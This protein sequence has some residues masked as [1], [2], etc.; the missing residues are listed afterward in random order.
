V[1]VSIGGLVLT[2]VGSAVGQIVGLDDATATL[3]TAAFV[4]L[5]ALIG[6]GIMLAS[7][8][9]LSDYG[10]RR[11]THLPATWWAAPL[12]VAPVAVIAISGFE[13]KPGLLVPYLALTLAVG[14]NEEI[15]FRGLALAAVRRK[16]VKP[17]IAAASLLF[18]VL[19]LANALAGKPGLYLILQLGFATLVGLVLAELVAITGSLWIPIAWHFV[20]DFFSFNSGPALDARA[21]L[22][23][24][25]ISVVLLAYAVVLWRRLPAG[26]HD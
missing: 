19:H 14:F 16:A 22:A 26:P 1:L 7:R 10:F 24:S 15:W 8:R 3:V 9:P 5:S 21:L 20:Y 4:A 18:G 23:S 17:A 2:A 13:P 12:L 25:V 6:A 11:P